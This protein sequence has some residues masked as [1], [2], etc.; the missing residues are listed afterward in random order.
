MK[1]V[2]S[3]FTPP[4]ALVF[5]HAPLLILIAFSFNASRFTVWEGFLAAMV[6]AAL[7]DPQLAEGL[8]NSLII[9]MVAAAL[10]TLS[11]L[12]RLTGCGSAASP[13]LSGRSICRW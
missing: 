4:P 7:N 11:E 3:G 13:L 12:W 6:R 9:A 5:L 10:S 2:C 8:V 1:R